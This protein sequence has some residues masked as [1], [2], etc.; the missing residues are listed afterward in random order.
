M[1]EV[2]NFF[3]ASFQEFFSGFFTQLHKLR[4]LRRSFSSFSKLHDLGWIHLQHTRI[5]VVFAC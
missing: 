3:Q 2:L 1:A 5:A 4:S